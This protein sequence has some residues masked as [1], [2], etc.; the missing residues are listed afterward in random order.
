MDVTNFSEEFNK[1]VIFFCARILN[2]NMVFDWNKNAFYYNITYKMIYHNPEHN[3]M[4]YTIS[5]V[6]IFLNIVKLM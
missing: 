1:L 3:I 2:I 6:L 5:H 4:A